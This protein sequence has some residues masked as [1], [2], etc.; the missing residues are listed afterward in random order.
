MLIIVAFLTGYWLL[1]L[2]ISVRNKRWNDMFYGICILMIMYITMNIIMSIV[3]ILAV[4]YL[5]NYIAAK[6]REEAEREDQEE[7]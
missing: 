4:I 6:E 5:H 1:Y 7:E 3:S 2:F